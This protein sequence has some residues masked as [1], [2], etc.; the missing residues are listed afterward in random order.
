MRLPLFRALV[1]NTVA[2][3]STTCA[4]TRRTP[5]GISRLTVSLFSLY[6]LVGSF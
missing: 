5:N 1:G 2:V 6:S 3:R 4:V